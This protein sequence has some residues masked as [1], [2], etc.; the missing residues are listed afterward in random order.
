MVARIAENVLFELASDPK[1]TL[2]LT[3]EIAGEAPTG[4]TSD[5][6]DVVQSNLRD[7]K[8]D[9]GDAGFEEQ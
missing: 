9:A 6:V 5:V 7:L 8:I 2:K 4:Y 3:L 1:A